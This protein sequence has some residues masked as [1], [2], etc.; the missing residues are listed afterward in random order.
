MAM[1]V[2]EKVW[3]AFAAGCLPIYQG[4]PNF[5]EDFAPH[6]LSVI[7]YNSSTM[8]P[9]SLAGQCPYRSIINEI[10]SFLLKY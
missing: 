10:N 3:Q 5:I 4:A 2:S 6:P 9:K 7:V 1:Q 8:T